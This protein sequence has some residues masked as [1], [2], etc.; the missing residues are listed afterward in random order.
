M[1]FFQEIELAE[2]TFR[3]LIVVY[4]DKPDA[5]AP[6]TTVPKITL[7]SFQ[8]IPIADFEVV[9][10]AQKP[11]ER[12]LD[13]LK[14]LGAIAAGMLGVYKQISSAE[15]E[16]QSFQEMVNSARQTLLVVGG[17]MMKIY[18]QRSA[19][20]K[21]YTQVI[22]TY[23]YDK[24]MNNNQGLL[25][26]IVDSTLQQEV[27]EAV[28]AYYFLWSN[29]AQ[30]RD[31]LDDV[32]ESFLAQIEESVDFEAEDGLGKLIIEDIVRS[33]QG[34][35]EDSHLFHLNISRAIQTIQGKIAGFNEDTDR[36]C[37]FCPILGKGHK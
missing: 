18:F 2:P 16:N 9:L 33:D 19:S 1:N 36:L 31:E 8:N 10:P 3:E 23:L 22:T 20:Q 4:R 13:T 12:A 17:Y 6:P 26:Y 29:Q 37:P 27:K 25:P 32:C 5:S 24:S 15:T 28:I 14:Q 21:K 35:N 11:K 7:K 34:S 30:T